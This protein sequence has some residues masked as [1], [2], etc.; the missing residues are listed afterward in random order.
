MERLCWVLILAASA[1]LLTGNLIIGGLV[2]PTVFAHLNRDSGGLV[3]G[4]ILSSYSQWISWV[5]VILMI[6]SLLGMITLRILRG[7]YNLILYTVV[8]AVAMFILQV[9]SNHLVQEGTAVR[10]RIRSLNVPPAIQA[11]DSHYQA[12]SK[13]FDYLRRNSTTA[14]KWKTLFSAVIMVTAGIALA[15]PRRASRQQPKLLGADA[16][17][18]DATVATVAPKSPKRKDSG[19]N[20]AKAAATAAGTSKSGT[21]AKGAASLP[22]LATIAIISS[23]LGGCIVHRGSV[24]MHPDTPSQ[25]LQLQPVSAMAT[26][27]DQPWAGPT[28]RVSPFAVELPTAVWL[29]DNEGS[30]MRGDVNPQTPR[31]WWQRFPV[32]IITDL[33]PR[34][35]ELQAH[36]VIHPQ[37]IVPRDANELDAEAYAFGYASGYRRPAD[38]GDAPQAAEQTD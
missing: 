27:V 14:F 16:D 6:L 7:H 11:T 26:V 31:P 35:I 5:L 3:F 9:W 36:A 17:M 12:L 20:K 32:D 25:S 23:A 10:D 22:F 33:W 15:G 18:D 30:L 28:Q 38:A 1:A 34:P 24:A 21:S 2:A 29:R 4:D 8:L 19:K 13:R 37:A